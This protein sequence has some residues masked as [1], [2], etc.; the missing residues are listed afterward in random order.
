MRLRTRPPLLTYLLRGSGD[1]EFWALLSCLRFIR[2]HFPAKHICIL[3]DNSEVVSVFGKAAD[4]QPSQRPTQ[5]KSETHR[6]NWLVGFKK[7]YTIST[8]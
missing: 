2:L 7:N 6:Y 3:S 8:Q 5:P 4:Y 1:A